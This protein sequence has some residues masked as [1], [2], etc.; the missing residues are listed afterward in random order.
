MKVN[1]YRVM[2]RIGMAIVNTNEVVA[3][4]FGIDSFMRGDY[5]AMCLAFI[6]AYCLFLL[7][8]A[9]YDETFREYRERIECLEKQNEW[10]QKYF[11]RLRKAVEELE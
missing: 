7:T 1:N 11:D 8:G 5:L 2:S 6:A 3:L 9:I 10:Y 4:L